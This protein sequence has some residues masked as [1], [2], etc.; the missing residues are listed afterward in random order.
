M[1]VSAI[2]RVVTVRD[3]ARLPRG[4]TP[5]AERATV[6]P[7]GV[8]VAAVG[9]LYLTRQV[10]VKMKGATA[11]EPRPSRKAAA[12]I[13]PAAEE[14]A[15]PGRGPGAATR[16]ASGPVGVG[17]ARPVAGA[18]SP[19]GDPGGRARAGSATSGVVK[20]K[21]R[22]RKPLQSL[23]ASGAPVT[24][25]GGPP[26][27]RVD[28]ETL[29]G[30][31][32]EARPRKAGRATEIEARRTAPVAEMAQVAAPSGGGGPLKVGLVPEA[33][34]RP[35]EVA[36][37]R[38]TRVGVRAEEPPTEVP[39]MTAAAGH[40]AEVAAGVGPVAT[41]ATAAVRQASWVGRPPN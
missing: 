11:P 41:V 36:P 33:P 35:D 40:G 4:R 29:P 15:V 27:G 31:R 21:E 13:L 32:Q 20:L 39:R 18:G 34:G 16:R 23:A 30:E 3:G 7:R 28:T 22:G 5:S 37:R 25:P 24:I 38:I 8:G 2:P 12:A 14:G 1:R 26:P 19:V 10:A 9:R 6:S 17:P